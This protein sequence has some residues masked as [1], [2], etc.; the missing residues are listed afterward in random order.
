[1]SLRETFALNLKRIRQ[2]RRL[3]Q[4]D[5]AGLAGIDRTY[6]S[7]LERCEYSATLDMIEKIARA[8]GAA[9]ATLLEDP[10]LD[11]L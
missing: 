3:S 2:A 6:V 1:M 11:P 5:L 10:S 8:L 7:L 4:E 9:P